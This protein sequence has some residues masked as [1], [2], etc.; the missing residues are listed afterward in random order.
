MSVSAVTAGIVPYC[1]TAHRRDS[2]TIF[3]LLPHLHPSTVC[4]HHV[5]DHSWPQLTTAHLSKQPPP[6]RLTAA[7]EL[8]QSLQAPSHLYHGSRIWPVSQEPGPLWNH[9]RSDKKLIVWECDEEAWRKF[10]WHEFLHILHTSFPNISPSL[11]VLLMQRVNKEY[12]VFLWGYSWIWLSA[13]WEMA[14]KLVW[15]LSLHWNHNI[16]FCPLCG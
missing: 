13:S 15:G 14:Y 5:H 4:G 3:N 2:T 11:F 8:R 16:Y 12:F 1:I 7:T 9:C 10:P 6:T